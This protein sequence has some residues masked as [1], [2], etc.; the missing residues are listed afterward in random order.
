MSNLSEPFIS[1]FRDEFEAPAVQ[2]DDPNAAWKLEE[3]VARV[4]HCYVDG[5]E[6][7]TRCTVGSDDTRGGDVRLG[8][9]PRRTAASE[10]SDIDS[11]T[12]QKKVQLRS[13]V[14]KY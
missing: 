8:R 6:L 12:E 4:S 3:A 7:S 1:V 10:W 9:K 2:R 13:T 11:I 14:L 5:G